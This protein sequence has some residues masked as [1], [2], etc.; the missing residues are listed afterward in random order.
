M[1][2][3]KP[4]KR[5]Q[6]CKENFEVFPY[7][8]RERFCS[9]ACAVEFEKKNKTPGKKFTKLNNKSKT[10]FAQLVNEAI[11]KA[12]EWVRIRDKEK[13][14][15]TCGKKVTCSMH[16]YDKSTFPWMAA[17]AR[18]QFGGCFDC[19]RRDKEEQ[20]FKDF[21]KLMVSDR[22]GMEE[23][24]YIRLVAQ[25]GREKTIKHPRQFYENLISEY[26]SLIKKG[27]C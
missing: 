16:L 23:F 15:I 8:Q 5:C 6:N 27:L 21:F 9:F 25:A 2:I 22:V 1:R 10:P 24:K 26:K 13:G 20:G 14:C 12:A 4:R 7:N 3:K 11:E 17:L 19:N 18:A